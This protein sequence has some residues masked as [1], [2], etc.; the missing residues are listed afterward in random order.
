[1]LKS[2]YSP[3]GFEKLLYYHSTTIIFLK[4]VYYEALIRVRLY[5]RLLR[6]SA[7]SLKGNSSKMWKVRTEYTEYTTKNTVI[8]PNFLVW[9][10]GGK[11]QFPHSFGRCAFPQNFHTRKF[12]EITVFYA[13][14]TDIIILS[15]L[16]KLLPRMF[17]STH[18]TIY[19]YVKKYNIK[20][21]INILHAFFN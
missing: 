17:I 12:R 16:T 8:S 6:S 4:Q 5:L 7:I 18:I 1:M 19:F 3:Q 15:F 13:V 11:A 14:I 9:K 10:F 21:N 20:R 2:S